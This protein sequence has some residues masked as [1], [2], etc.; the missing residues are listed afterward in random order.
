[1]ESLPIPGEVYAESIGI[2]QLPQKTTTENAEE[3][4]PETKK[5]HKLKSESNGK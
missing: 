3:D 5:K 4:D 1:M 2:L